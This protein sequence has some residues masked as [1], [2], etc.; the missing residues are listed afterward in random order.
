MQTV[1]IEFGSLAKQGAKPIWEYDFR[2]SKCAA[3]RLFQKLEFVRKA[4]RRRN[5]NR[6]AMFH[7]N[8]FFQHAPRLRFR[9]WT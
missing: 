7:H 2:V 8:K 3:D 1:D 5:K 9:P 4:T 6:L